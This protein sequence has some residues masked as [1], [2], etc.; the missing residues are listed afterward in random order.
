[1]VQGFRTIIDTL[2]ASSN[3]LA[4]SL[5]ICG[6][7]TVIRGHDSAGLALIATGSTLLNN[8]VRKEPSAPDGGKNA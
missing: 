7:V 6:A 8:G 3:L 4:F 1:M 2:N 5:I